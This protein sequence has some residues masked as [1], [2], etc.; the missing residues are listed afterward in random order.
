ML[1]VA[2]TEAACVTCHLGER[3]Q[4]GREDLNEALVTVERAGCYAC[5]VVPGMEQTPSAGQTFAAS[6]GNSRRNG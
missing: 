6:A 4:P 1:P 2:H 3:Y 5:H